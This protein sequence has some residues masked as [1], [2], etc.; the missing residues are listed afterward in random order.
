[1]QLRAGTCTCDAGVEQSPR[2][3]RGGTTVRVGPVGINLDGQQ[4]KPWRGSAYTQMV[5]R[6]HTAAEREE[7]TR[8]L[9]N[10]C[11]RARYGAARGGGRAGP[12]PLRYDAIGGRWH[13]LHM[14]GPR[15]S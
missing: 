1:M 14:L 2:K 4:E 9:T 5:H 7:K 12:E 11:G 6:P 15:A 13:M 10:Q 3:I 8:Q